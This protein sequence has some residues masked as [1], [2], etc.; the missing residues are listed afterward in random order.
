MRSRTKILSFF[1]LFSLSMV[2]HALE[3]M[4][5]LPPDTQAYLRISNTTNF[6]SKLK[7]SPF[8]K[9]WVDPQ[10]QD[11]IGHPKASIWTNLLAE[12][13]TETEKTIAL[14][15]YKMLGGEVI[16]AFD[17]EIEKITLI[18]AMK[19]EDFLQ[20]LE[21]D[22]KLNN[23]SDDPIDIV[24]SNFQGVEIIQHIREDEKDDASWQAFE[25]GTFIMGNSREW[26]EHGI[27]QLQKEKIKEPK[28]NPILNLNL[29]LKQFVDE[30]VEEMD[31]HGA[32][33]STRSLVDALG[34][35]GL[36]KL[37][38][39]LELQKDEMTIDSNLE[40]ADLT[41]GIFSLL[42]PQPSKIPAVTFIPESIASFEVGR[43]NLLRLWQEIPK[44]LAS[45]SPTAGPH[46]DMVLNLF[47]QQT[48]VD[49][50]QDLLAHLDTQYLSYHQIKEESPQSTVFALALKDRLAFKTAL[51]SILTSPTLQMQLANILETEEFLDHTLYIIKADN[52][53]ESVAFGVA[54]NYL[55]YS[56]PAELRQVIRS[57]NS[58]DSN[59]LSNA[60]PLLKELHQHISSRAFSFGATNWQKNM[61]ILIRELNNP[62]IAEAVARGWALQDLAF[63]QP[64]FSKL[65][66]AKHIASFFNISYQYVEATDDGLHQKIL[67]KY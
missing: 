21:L 13:N 35:A 39:T 26:V 14:E 7:Q 37:S 56:H 25:N 51:G 9:L 28:G 44:I 29:P 50:E 54:D 31:G 52:P 1:L 67:L 38:V 32:A 34:L 40:I 22:E 19:K 23:I 15:Q 24:K 64:N 36:E 16:V 46:L 48:G 49:I 60:S 27:A 58:E 2:A 17:Q 10:F 59:G 61:V 30:W 3:R 53:S 18:A 66:A 43:I 41:Q 42:D 12:E 57:L 45:I 5:L 62:E 47:M 33:T 8:G 20:S 6:W 63:P 55:F 4:E 11:F 65:P